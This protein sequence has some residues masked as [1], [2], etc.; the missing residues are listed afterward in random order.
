MAAEPERITRVPMV[1]PNHDAVVE[2][3]EDQ[4]ESY[5]DAGWKKLR[6]RR[7]DTGSVP[8]QRPDHR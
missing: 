1:F 4:V 6:T 7:A 8:A 5:I 2:V 3:P